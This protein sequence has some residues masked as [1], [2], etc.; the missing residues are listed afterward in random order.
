MIAYSHDTIFA[1]YDEWGLVQNSA[2]LFDSHYLNQNIGWH[3]RFL[4][5]GKE[6]HGR[7]WSFCRSTIVEFIIRRLNA[8]KGVRI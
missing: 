5:N 6:Y 7:A 4:V 3:V 8:V 2:I 1:T